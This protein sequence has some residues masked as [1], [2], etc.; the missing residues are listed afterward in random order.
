MG[1]FYNRRS[2]FLAVG[3]FVGFQL[4]S[5]ARFLPEVVAH[6][7]AMGI[8]LLFF[9]VFIVLL[10]TQLELGRYVANSAAAMALRDSLIFAGFAYFIFCSIDLPF[11]VLGS[12]ALWF[13]AISSIQ[14]TTGRIIL[15]SQ[16]LDTRFGRINTYLVGI[17]LGAMTSS[18]LLG[19]GT[20][21][22]SLV[23][24]GTGVSVIIILRVH[25]YAATAGGYA[26][27]GQIWFVRDLLHDS[28]GLSLLAA[29]ICFGVIFWGLILEQTQMES[30]V[31]GILLYIGIS[32]RILP[33]MHIERAVRFAMYLSA[34]STMVDA[35]I[36]SR[37]FCSM[38]VLP[39]SAVLIYSS[40]R[41]GAFCP[42]TIMS[43][44]ERLGVHNLGVTIGG[45]F[46]TAIYIIASTFSQRYWI[47]GFV[48]FTFAYLLSFA[49]VS[50]PR[51]EHA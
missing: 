3:F 9:S 12:F 33:A 27:P 34:F 19:A 2:P 31:A 25:L 38:L 5:I 49:P 29:S 17:V 50:P 16:D 13:I 14:I 39:F 26:M 51:E 11:W 44:A 15:L 46:V 42:I 18:G 32:K 35:F 20:T 40:V 41:I 24:T 43:S 28:K 7:E 45:M 48:V 36:W 22:Q 4:L 30:A 23:I 1:I 21:V 47:M 10:V 8:D 6:S 37:L